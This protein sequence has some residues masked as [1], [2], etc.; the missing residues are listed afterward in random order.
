MQYTLVI[1]VDHPTVHRLYNT[2]EGLP[3]PPH[4][5]PSLKNVVSARSL[6]AVEATVMVRD[7]G[8]GRWARDTVLPCSNDHSFGTNQRTH[9]PKQVGLRGSNK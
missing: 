7:K 6:F 9:D 1:E 5:Q 3:V 8:A 2:L 4:R